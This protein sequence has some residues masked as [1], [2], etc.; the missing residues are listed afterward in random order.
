MSSHVSISFEL[1]LLINWIM[2]NEKTL[3]NTLIKNALEKGFL[4]ELEKN[5]QKDTIQTS[6]QL[7]AII[8]E[9]L[10]QLEKALIKNLET[11]AQDQQAT[12]AV[13]PIFKKMN[14]E[15]ID[16]KTIWLS[17]QQAKTK[18]NKSYPQKQPAAENEATTLLFEQLLKN[19]KPTKK[20]PLN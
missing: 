10:I 15:N 16:L 8:L 6:D 4:Q 7:Y 12:E 11:I 18:F 17:L 5:N 19:W 14:F 20:E 1:I 3:I 9:F 2:K 13:L